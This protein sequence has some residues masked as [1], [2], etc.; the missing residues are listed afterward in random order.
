MA[1]YRA[2]CLTSDTPIYM[3]VARFNWNVILL[4][5]LSHFESHGRASLPAQPISLF[6]TTLDVVVVMLESKRVF[7]CKN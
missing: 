2:I 5:F 4:Y 6:L 1:R 3:N 7:D